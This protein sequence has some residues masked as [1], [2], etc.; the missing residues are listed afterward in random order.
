[1][2]SLSGFFLGVMLMLAIWMVVSIMRIQEFLWTRGY[3]MNPLAMTTRDGGTRNAGL[4][5]LRQHLDQPPAP[6]V[7]R[8][9][10][11]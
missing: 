11:P 1:M 10:P 3:K 8:R 6:T 7:V 9:P 5:V 2:S 4:P